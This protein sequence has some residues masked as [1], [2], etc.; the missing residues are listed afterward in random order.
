[1]GRS[2]QIFAQRHFHQLEILENDGEDLN[3]FFKRVFPDI[4]PIQ[5][6]SSLCRFRQP[7]HQLDERRFPRAVAPD[8]RKV[9]LQFQIKG[10]ILQRVFTLAR[11]AV[12]NMIEGQMIFA[13]IPFL[14]RQRPFIAHIRTLNE[15]FIAVEVFVTVGDVVIAGRQCD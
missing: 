3:V 14:H 4:N 12:R 5:Q 2:R 8:D 9:F 11:I 7:A 6:D 10:D 15:G 13:V 1:M